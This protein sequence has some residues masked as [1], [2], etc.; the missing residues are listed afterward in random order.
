MEIWLF[1]A[2]HCQAHCEGEADA[3]HRV[4]RTPKVCPRLRSLPSVT[5][6]S[7]C[8]SRFCYIECIRAAKNYICSFC[9]S[10][11]ALLTNIWYLIRYN[12]FRRTHQNKE[13]IELVNWLPL[14]MEPQLAPNWLIVAVEKNSPSPGFSL[15]TLWWLRSRLQLLPPI[16][17]LL[18][19]NSRI[20]QLVERFAS[21]GE[22]PGSNPWSEVFYKLPRLESTTFRV[23]AKVFFRTTWSYRDIQ[24]LCASIHSPPRLKWKDSSASNWGV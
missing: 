1:S 9:I 20:A 22:V 12:E 21:H 6:R 16:Y 2:T 24:G 14:E 23:E 10:F 17:L 3:S 7:R 15:G 11:W 5:H 19:A 13:E 4:Y 18:T 8:L